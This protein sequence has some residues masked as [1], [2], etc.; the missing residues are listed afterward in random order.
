M[1]HYKSLNSCEQDIITKS[2]DDPSKKSHIKNVLNP[3]K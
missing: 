1:A 3:L 2:K